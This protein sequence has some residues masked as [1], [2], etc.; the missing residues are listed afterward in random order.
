[1]DKELL[2]RYQARLRSVGYTDWE[3]GKPLPDI[4]LYSSDDAEAEDD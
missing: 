1:M 2:Q 4:K 3:T